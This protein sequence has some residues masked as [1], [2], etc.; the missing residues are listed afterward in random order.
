LEFCV[1]KTSIIFP[2]CFSSLNYPC[3]SHSFRGY[4]KAHRPQYS[5]RKERENKRAMGV[6]CDICDICKAVIVYPICFLLKPCSHTAC[7]RCFHEMVPAQV[8]LRCP[9]SGCRESVTSSALLE[10]TSTE[11]NN[12]SISPKSSSSSPN[13]PPSLDGTI[14]TTSASDASNRN[15]NNNNNNS[16]KAE[17]M[18]PLKNIRE[19]Q[20]VS[21]FE[22]DEQMDP[23]RHWAIKK[24]ELYTGLVYVAYRFSDDEVSVS[25]MIILASTIS[26]L[27]KNI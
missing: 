23:F 25:N 18:H 17:K 19:I 24:P 2:T 14:V 12:S 5:N 7:V 16:P 1:Q 22:P 26:A 6:T 9:C 13:Q 15:N 21:H 27:T 11:C 3:L 20:E 4:R 10:I 8:F